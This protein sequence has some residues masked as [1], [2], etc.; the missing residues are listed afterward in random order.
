[1]VLTS[2]GRVKRDL[3]PTP[4]CQMSQIH[5]QVAVTGVHVLLKMRGPKAYQIPIKCAVNAEYSRK[6]S[7]QLWQVVNF[8]E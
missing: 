1:M 4:I 2:K 7:S 3:P 6:I 8:S 5:I